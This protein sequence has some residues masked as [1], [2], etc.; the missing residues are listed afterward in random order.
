MGFSEDLEFID[1]PDAL[2]NPF[3]ARATCYPSF[4]PVDGNGMGMRNTKEYALP[5]K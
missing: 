2:E 5:K 4:C 3:F 1:F